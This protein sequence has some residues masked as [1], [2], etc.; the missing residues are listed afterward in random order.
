MARQSARNRKHE[1]KAVVLPPPRKPSKRSTGQG[2]TW[3]D[4]GL[5][6]NGSSSALRPRPEPPKGRRVKETA[7]VAVLLKNRGQVAANA[8]K[9]KKHKVTTPDP[10]S[11][12]DLAMDFKSTSFVIRSSSYADSSFR[13]HR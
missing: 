10:P 8:K 4:H 3:I 5:G 11:E 13:W 2:M 9:Q 7:S 1:R 6:N 12:S